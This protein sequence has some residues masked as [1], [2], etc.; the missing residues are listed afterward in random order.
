MNIKTIDD[1]IYKVHN[2]KVLNKNDKKAKAILSRA[3]EQVLPIM[4]KRKFRVELLSEFL[5]KNPNLLGLNIV[6]KSEIKIRLRKTKGG[7]IFHFNDIM[8]TLLHELV[9]IVH[10]RHDKS[11]YELLDKITWEYNEL[12]VYNK[13]GISV[14]DTVSSNIIKYNLNTNNIMK[15]NIILDITNMNNVIN[16]Y[17]NDPKFMA[18]Q[19]AEKRLL[20]NFMNNQGEI[21]N[22]SLESCLTKKQRENILNNRKK[23]DDIICCLDNDIILIDTIS[24]LY[25]KEDD[26]KEMFTQKK[27]DNILFLED[28]KDNVNN[29]VHYTYMQTSNDNE[30]I[31]EK[32][33]KKLMITQNYNNQCEDTPD[34][35]EILTP[36]IKENKNKRKNLN[37]SNNGIFD[38]LPNDGDDN[39]RGLK[40]KKG[41]HKDKKNDKNDEVIFLK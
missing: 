35:I 7:E 40:R 27:S 19:A 13:K 17:E 16:I 31:Q 23:Y 2:I 39:L 26:H 21:I 9:H 6:N 15:D 32:K 36:N 34:V 22:A 28:I 5:P 29:D 38:I 1:V 37:E 11:F 8:G 24:D 12:Y 20:N 14:G 10:S 18:A 25:D 41:N 33:E 3:A 4:K 30:R